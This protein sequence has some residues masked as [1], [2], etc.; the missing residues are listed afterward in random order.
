MKKCSRVLKIDTKKKKAWLGDIPLKVKIRGHVLL[1]EI[2]PLIFHQTSVEPFDGLHERLAALADQYE[3]D[4]E[5]L[6]KIVA[7]TP[8]IRI[9]YLV[10]RL[11]IPRY[12]AEKIFAQYL[13]MGACHQY[14]S[15]LKKDTEYAK[16]L[17]DKVQIFTSTT[18]KASMKERYKYTIPTDEQLADMTLED[19]KDELVSCQRSRGKYKKEDLATL[20][21]V[22][23]TKTRLQRQTKKARKDEAGEMLE[24]AKEI[25]EEE[26]QPT[27]H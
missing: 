18:A 14:Q 21:E 17:Q 19:I 15:A 22:I 27:V 9:V 12:V 23:K 16:Y 5:T 25:D 2:D 3:F 7:L 11:K 4:V 1:L 20:Q 10:S 24:M 13:D 26:D 6:H 8:T